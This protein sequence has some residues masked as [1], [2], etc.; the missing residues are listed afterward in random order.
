MQKKS[1]SN[2]DCWVT[3]IVQE[4]YLNKAIKLS[5]RGVLGSPGL[6]SVE[7]LWGNRRPV[8]SDL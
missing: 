1:R 7:Q 2:L 6:K 3:V 5:L 8:K 4:A